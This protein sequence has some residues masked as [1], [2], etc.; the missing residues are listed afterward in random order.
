MGSLLD[1]LNTC[2]NSNIYRNFFLLSV[3]HDLSPSHGSFLDHV[4]D[5]SRVQHVLELAQ[6]PSTLL[7]PA[8]GVDEDQQGMGAFQR[9][10]LE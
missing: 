5:L 2:S 9:G 10:N 7:S 8:L 6:E 1:M 3:T 4:V